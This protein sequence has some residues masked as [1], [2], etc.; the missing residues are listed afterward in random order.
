MRAGIMALS[1]AVAATAA[2]ATAWWF[3]WS[4]PLVAVPATNVALPDVE[5]GV[6]QT[7]MVALLCLDGDEAATIDRI[8]VDPA[9]LTVT[10]FAVRRS[11]AGPGIG[12]VD[13]PLRESGLDGGRTVAAECAEGAW[14]ELAVELSRVNGPAHTDVVS[15]HWRAGVRSGVL[16]VEAPVTLCAPAPRDERC[17]PVAAG[18]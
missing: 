16:P 11:S 8:T 17:T 3:L 10:D 12:A 15:I 6:P 14:S 9:G 18:S 7:V 4:S 5:L 2:G 1:A 13:G